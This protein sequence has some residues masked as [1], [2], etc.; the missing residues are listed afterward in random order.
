MVSASAATC[1]LVLALSFL[2]GRLKRSRFCATA[3]ADRHNHH[4]RHHTFWYH[5]ISD[6]KVTR[7]VLDYDDTSAL[8]LQ[9]V[10]Y[11]KPFIC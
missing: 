1:P 6:H 2:R 11:L 7:S 5:V 4:K 3:A 9:N 10:L 8:T